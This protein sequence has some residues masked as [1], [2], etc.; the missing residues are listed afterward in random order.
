M[1]RVPA[2]PVLAAVA[3]TVALSLAVPATTAY[4]DHHP[5][6]LGGPRR[7]AAGRARLRRRLGPACAATELRA[8]GRALA[9]HVPGPR[10]QPRVEGRAQR[11]LG[12]EL[13]RGRAATSPSPRAGDP[14]DVHVRPAAHRVSVVPADAAAPAGPADRALAGDSLRE[15]LTRE[16]LYFV[17]ADRFENGDPTNDRAGLGD[18]P[19]GLRLRPDRHRLLPRRGPR[20]ASSTGSTTSR[21]S[22][23]PRSGSP[24]RSRTS[25]SRARP[26]PRRP[27][28][29][30]TGS[31]TSPR[32]TP[33][34]APTRTCGSWSTSPTSAASRSSSTSS[35]TTPPTSSPTTRASTTPTATCPTSAPRTSPTATRP[36][37]QFDDRDYADGTPPFPAV[38]R[39]VV[40][41]RADRPGGR[42]GR[43]GPRLAQRPD[44]L[45]QPRDVD[46]RRR[47]QHL[48]RLPVRSVLRPRRPVD[49]APAGR[50]RG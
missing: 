42:A 2:S 47:G 14:A 35:P 31:P 4:A 46:V 37:P 27:A 10:R 24:R 23:P 28:T 26:A 17:M 22:A 30:A 40:P 18:G 13:R 38:D 33:T 15:P 3:A 12:R 34:W 7:L 39:A 6:P 19:A 32:S 21:A 50:A 29:T 45:P 41:L 36:G 48:R 43:E 9:G 20:R 11:H 16:R 8:R 44:A 5:P 25:R 1:S 49:R